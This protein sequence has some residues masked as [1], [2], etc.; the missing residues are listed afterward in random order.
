MKSMSRL[1]SGCAAESYR[2]RCSFTRLL[3]W[4]VSGPLSQL[5]CGSVNRGNVT[6]FVEKYTTAAA[7]FMVPLINLDL[8]MAVWSLKCRSSSSNRR[9]RKCHP[10][11]IGNVP[12][13]LFE[14]HVGCVWLVSA[15]VPQ[16]G[17]LDGIWAPNY[18]KPLGLLGKLS[19]I[20]KKVSI[21]YQLRNTGA[22]S[23]TPKDSK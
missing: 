9:T 3:H 13:P 16:L 14:V 21:Q 23:T 12:V 6:H 1:L 10:T 7:S 19:T 4:R 22:S 2:R 8:V 5:L 20:K 18:F 11:W 17:L 15:F